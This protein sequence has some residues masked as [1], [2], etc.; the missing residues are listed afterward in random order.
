[1]RNQSQDEQLE[2]WKKESPIP[3]GLESS[4]PGSS[5]QLPDSLFNTYDTQFTG[6]LDTDFARKRPLHLLVADDNEINRKVICVILEKLGYRCSEARNGA[7]ALQLFKSKKFDYIFM[8]LDMPEV[9]GIEAAKSIRDFEKEQ[10]SGEPT[11]KSEIIAVTAN[12]SSETRLKCRRAGMNGY[13]EKP[14][15]AQTIKDQLLR[16]WPRIRSRRAHSASVD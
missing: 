13:L 10:S 15:T 6:T 14:I 1:M 2:L 3:Q 9:T 4:S 12:V 5:E 8:D 16:S 11:P 7:E